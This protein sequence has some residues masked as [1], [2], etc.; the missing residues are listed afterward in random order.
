MF[1]ST[2]IGEVWCTHGLIIE[3]LSIE[4]QLKVLAQR[5]NSA[6][7]KQIFE[8]VWQYNKTIDSVTNGNP[9]D[10]FFNQKGYPDIQERLQ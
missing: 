3:L 8:A 6:P 10:V 2:A 4:I 7:D 1:Y 9:K 5:H